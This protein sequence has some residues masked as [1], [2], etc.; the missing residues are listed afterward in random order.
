[1]CV[2]GLHPAQKTQEPPTPLVSG[3]CL[4]L[5]DPTACRTRPHSPTQPT[6]HSRQTSKKKQK[7]T[8]TMFPPMSIIHPNTRRDEDV[9]PR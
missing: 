2:Q 7:R 1:M 9:C 3:G 5:Q 8:F 6:G 4:S